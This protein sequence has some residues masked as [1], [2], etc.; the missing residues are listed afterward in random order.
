MPYQVE[1]LED[2]YYLRNLHTNIYAK[3][4][5]KSKETAISQAKNWMRYRGENPIVQGNRIIKKDLKK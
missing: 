4:A 3:K 1:K 2:K 5:F